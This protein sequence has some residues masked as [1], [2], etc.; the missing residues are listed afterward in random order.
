M[1]SMLN[2]PFQAHVD[3][4][5][6]EHRASH[7]GPTFAGPRWAIYSHSWPVTTQQH[8]ASSSTS[9]SQRFRRAVLKNDLLLAKRIA[10]KAIA[11]STSTALEAEQQQQHWL[12]RQFDLETRRPSTHTVRA[13]PSSA[14]GTISPSGK[15]SQPPRRSPLKL[16]VLTLQ[17]AKQADVPVRER[18]LL[19]HKALAQQPFDIKNIDHTAAAGSF[20]AKCS[21]ALAIESGADIELI[22]WLLDMGHEAEE[23]SRDADNN[24]IVTIAALHNRPDVIELYISHPTIS[25]I[26]L[27]DWSNTSLGQT[28]LHLASIKG[29]EEVIRVRMNGAPPPDKS[30][31]HELMLI[32]TCR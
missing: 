22:Q 17:E 6:G 9:L 25:G 21:L 11:L 2:L 4:M 1:P 27:L 15:E 20:D 24:S 5:T 8:Q 13:L 29:H 26:D 31:G 30:N 10:S 23:L 28:A 12:D 19:R 7:L 32:P 16:P 18:A 14:S 3:T